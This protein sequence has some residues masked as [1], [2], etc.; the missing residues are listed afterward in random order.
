MSIKTKTKNQFTDSF[1]YLQSAALS[2]KDICQ[3]TAN[4]LTRLLPNRVLSTANV[5]NT[6]LDVAQDLSQMVLLHVEDSLIENNINIAQKEISIRGLA[7]L[8]GHQAVRPISSKGVLKIT[9]NYL[10]RTTTPV[11]IFSN[12]EFVC[13]TTGIK[14][15]LNEQLI[16]ASTSSSTLLV[17][18]IEGSIEKEQIIAKGLK[19]EKIELDS[20]YPI[21]NSNIKVYVNNELWTV[22]DSLYDMGSLSKQYLIKNGIGNQVDICFGNRVYGRQ[23][24]EGDI[25]NIEYLT[26][27]GETGNITSI[28]PKFKITAGIYD[29]NGNEINVTDMLKIEVHS[30]FNLGSNGEH[31]EVTRNIAGYNSRAMVFSKPENIQ[32]YLSRLS[33]LS[34]IDAWSE[35]SS[36]VFNL[37]VAPN[38]TNKLT[39][40]ASYLDLNDSAFVLTAEQKASILE[41]LNESGRQSTS[42]EIIMHD[43]T[44][45]KYVLFC[46]IDGSVIDKASTKQKI[47]NAVSRIFLENTFL[48]VDLSG[49]DIIT[50][51]SLRNAILS[52]TNLTECNLDVFSEE[53]ELSRI[54][55]SVQMLSPSSK[56]VN[57]KRLIINKSLNLQNTAKVS[58]E[59]T[60]IK[61]SATDN[62]QLGFDELGSIRV[63]TRQHL[64]ILRGGFYKFDQSGEHVFLEKPLY[65]FQKTENGFEEI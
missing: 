24:S 25:I 56:L 5:F 55:G 59:S 13:E 14:Y 26:T 45:A 36:N 4:A 17:N 63:L 51:S 41:Y 50:I 18:V 52:E 10:A 37:V 57:D 48:D 32:A 39:T 31:I 61:V 2:V 62:L 54:N 33:I 12:T 3:K 30:G 40:Y 16:N 53:N 23:L 11:M 43:P 42:T 7:T 19:N 58:T 34:H 47:Q 20:I 65:I 1:N 60:K 6:T 64:P 44:F 27:S 8:T 28:N 46:Y 22:A 21:E 49:N 35:D 15:L 29:I 9:F 38:I